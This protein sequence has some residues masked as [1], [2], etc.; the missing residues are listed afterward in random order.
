MCRTVNPAR[1]VNGPDQVARY[2]RAR[3]TRELTPEGYIV[4]D[5][6]AVADVIDYTACLPD[7]STS[8]L[9]SRGDLSPYHPSPTQVDSRPNP[10]A[11]RWLHNA[12]K[13]RAPRL[14]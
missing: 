14:P 1:G 9:T 2:K 13:D 6:E 5:M 7:R 10:H 4:Q 3:E 8:R 12:P 11:G